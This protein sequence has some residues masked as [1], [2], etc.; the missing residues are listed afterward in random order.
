MYIRMEG[1]TIRYRVSKQEADSLING[2]KLSETTNFSADYS[3]TYSVK[4]TDEL[5]GFVVESGQL[6]ENKLSIMINRQQ[7]LDEIEG[8]PSKQ[9]ILI[10]TCKQKNPLNIYLEINLKLNR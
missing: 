1:Q 9:G 3:L 4:M 5:S 7:L 2:E 8:R 6:S 10:T